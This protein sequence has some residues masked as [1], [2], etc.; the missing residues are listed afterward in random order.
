MDDVRAPRADGLAHLAL[1]AADQSPF[2]QS[3]R[4]AGRNGWNREHGERV[5][6]RKPFLSLLV[7]GRGDHRYLDPLLALGP[8]DVLAP[9][10]ITARVMKDVVQHVEHAHDYGAPRM[11]P[12]RSTHRAS[13]SRVHSVEPCSPEPVRCC[14]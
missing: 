4:T 12:Y 11:A 6:G 1:E 3:R 13:T 14:L 7:V 8:K 5:L 9:R 10:A 2:P